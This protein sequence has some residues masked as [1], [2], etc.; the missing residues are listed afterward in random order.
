M[1]FLTEPLQI[2]KEWDDI[3]KIE[4]KILPTKNTLL[5]K[6]PFKNVGETKVSLG[7]QKLRELITSRPTGN[8]KGSSSI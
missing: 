6:L 8:A 1:H 4:R 2:R 7:K 5:L 3:I